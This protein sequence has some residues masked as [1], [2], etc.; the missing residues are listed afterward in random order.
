MRDG[1]SG[2]S[3]ACA[4]VRDE[5]NNNKENGDDGEGDDDSGDDGVDHG[6]VDG[7]GDGVEYNERSACED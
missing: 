1:G 4:I 2:R 6:G 5:V 3:R 7:S